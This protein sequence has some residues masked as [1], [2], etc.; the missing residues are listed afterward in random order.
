MSDED[1][2][3]PRP[4]AIKLD[5]GLNGAASVLIATLGARPAFESFAVPA[6]GLPAADAA[7]N[8]SQVSFVLM[9]ACVDLHAH[10]V[11]PS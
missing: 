5:V 4:V 2:R 7:I 8:L 3:G 1:T 11:V 6:A 9:K 10:E